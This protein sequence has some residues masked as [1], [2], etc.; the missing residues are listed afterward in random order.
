MVALQSACWDAT[1]KSNE[2]NQGLTSTLL[3]CSAEKMELDCPQA[4]KHSHSLSLQP[5]LDLLSSL[6][7]FNDVWQKVTSDWFCQRWSLYSDMTKRRQL[8]F[9]RLDGNAESDVIVCYSSIPDDRVTSTGGRPATRTA[10]SIEIGER[11]C[12]WSDLQL[13]CKLESRGFASFSN[14][15]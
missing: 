9:D 8:T 15:I 5:S 6:S 2:S 13:K 4:R 1:C 12:H 7:L 14:E 11:D 10:E 3:H